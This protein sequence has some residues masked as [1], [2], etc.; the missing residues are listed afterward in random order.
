MIQYFCSDALLI[1][2]SYI[3]LAKADHMVILKICRTLLYPAHGG[4]W[5]GR[6]V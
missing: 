6:D 2:L 5:Q 1:A 4:S 3:S